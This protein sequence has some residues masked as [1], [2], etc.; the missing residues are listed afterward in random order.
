MGTNYYVKPPGATSD[1]YD[2]W[3][4][5]GKSSIGWAFTFHAYPDPELSPQHVTWPV[6]DV[7]SWR[8]LLDLGEIRDEY[9]LP[10]TAEEL[11]VKIENK[12]HG[13]HHE[14]GTGVFHDTGGN[15]FL[16]VY[17]S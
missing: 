9:G 4:H 6:T 8:R 17:F 3:I 1:D 7:A 12:R 11:L 10:W 5:L 13:R 15:D 14:R 2:D 16:A